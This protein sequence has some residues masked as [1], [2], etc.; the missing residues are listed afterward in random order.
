[1]E[2]G[3]R[4]KKTSTKTYTKMAF[5]W[6]SSI[7]Q[8]IIY[9]FLFSLSLFES[10]QKKFYFFF[11]LWT[12]I[13]IDYYLNNL[14]INAFRFLQKKSFDEWDLVLNESFFLFAT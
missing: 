12:Q 8:N 2:I 7:D 11:I 3:K 6:C 4:E 1:M 13:Q 5:H 14:Q 9:F 10:S